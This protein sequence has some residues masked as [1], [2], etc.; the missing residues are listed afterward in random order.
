M[1]EASKSYSM[2]ETTALVA[3]IYASGSQ[4]QKEVKMEPQDPNKKLEDILKNFSF[5]F[6]QFPSN[7]SFNLF[8][9]Q[10]TPE[11]MI[12][13]LDEVD[14]VVDAMTSYPT[15]ENMLNEL[16]KKES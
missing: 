11:E 4:K 2:V 10:E 7:Q 15:A 3:A 6:I 9:N 13:R 14:Q 1:N 8:S 5:S 12:A 16:F